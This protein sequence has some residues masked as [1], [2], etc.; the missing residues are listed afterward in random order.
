MIGG[1]FRSAQWGSNPEVLSIARAAKARRIR[2]NCRR[3]RPIWSRRRHGTSRQ[4]PN[5]LLEFIKFVSDMTG[6]LIHHGNKGVRL[7]LKVVNTLGKRSLELREPSIDL[8]NLCIGPIVDLIYNPLELHDG[9]GQ[10]F[11]LGLRG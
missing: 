7:L 8:A 5:G 10:L 3:G 1:R 4:T 2:R 9:R 6:E 11:D